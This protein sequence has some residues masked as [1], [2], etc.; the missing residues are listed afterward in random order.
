MSRILRLGITGGIACGKSVVS[1]IL[2]E[3]GFPVMDA[4]ALAHQVMEPGR[5]AFQEIV[6]IFGRD[7]VGPSGG[8]DR[9]KL[10]A[11]VF[12]DRAEREKLNA[13]V[14][15]RVEA[16]MD[17]IFDEWERDGKTPVGFVEAALVVEAGYH[18]RLD[19]LL[20][21][22]CR[23]DQQLQRLMARGMTESQAR[24]RIESQMPIEEK[25]RYA[26]EKVDCS[27]TLGETRRQVE[28]LAQKLRGAGE[29]K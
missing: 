9:A 2:R 1:Q 20:V 16:E 24:A 13:I 15:P 18:K 17:R 6:S 26:T 23:P 27:S 21:A 7:V 22:W 14:H 8:I 12:A 25:L 19:G 29:S 11:V 28:K 5:P 3:L 4:D 10:A